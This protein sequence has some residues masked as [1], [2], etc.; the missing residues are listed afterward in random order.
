MP[1]MTIDAYIAYNSNENLLMKLAPGEGKKP[2]YLTTDKFIEEL[3]DTSVKLAANS[4]S[5]I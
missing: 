1:I 5:E 3:A 4:S 2:L